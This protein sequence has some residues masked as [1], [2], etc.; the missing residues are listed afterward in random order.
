MTRTRGVALNSALIVGAQSTQAI[1]VGAIAL[2]LPLLRADL[3]ISFAGAGLLAAVATL[4][5]AVM[6]VP[7][8]IL[9]D[10]FS[11]KRLFAIGLLGTNALAIVFAVSDSFPVMLGVQGV[12]G[13]FRSLMFIPGLILIT[14]HFSERR[15]ATAM[16]LF[17]AGGFSSNIVVSLIGPL[18]VGPLGWRGVIVASS[19]LGLVV[20]AG[21]WVFADDVPALPRDEAATG[22][23]RWVWRSREW[24]LLGVIQFVRLSIVSGFGFWLPAY[25][26]VERGFSLPAAG[27]IGAVSAAITAPANIFGGI[28]SDRLGRPMLVVGGALASLAVLLASIGLLTGVA[29]LVVVICLIA[30]FIQLYFGPLFAIPHLLFGDRVA[31]LSSG[32]G[33]MCANLGGF[34][35]AL[36]LG[37]LKDATGSF[38]WG[39]V[40]LAGTAVIGFIAVLALSRSVKRRLSIQT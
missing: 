34:A 36:T 21:F 12:A 26:I 18:L 27:L 39:F 19:I 4:S 38:E 30:I 11:P 22:S 10:R 2:F 35:S 9:A 33:N 7:A 5:Y 6:Q 37:I 25:L 3:G 1:A 40:A 32:F 20:L 15:R 13:V 24:W 8:G 14:R 28:I 29:E 23:T 31:G 17:V 16:G